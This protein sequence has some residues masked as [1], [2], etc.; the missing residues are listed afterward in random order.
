[1]KQYLDFM[2]H[3]RWHHMLWQLEKTLSD[4]LDYRLE[5]SSIDRMK[6]E[7]EKAHWMRFGFTDPSKT[8][9]IEALSAEAI[10]RTVKPRVPL[11]PPPTPASSAG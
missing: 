10:H 3:V 7:F 5:A 1:M 11:P 9:V 8:I 4:E 6:K 2:R